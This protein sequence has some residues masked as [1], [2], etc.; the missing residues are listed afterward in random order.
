MPNQ[1]GGLRP[2]VIQIFRQYLG[3]DPNQQEYQGFSDLIIKGTMQPMDLAFFIQGSP[4]FQQKQAPEQFKQYSQALMQGDQDFV[5]GQLGRAYDQASSKFRQMGRPYS[6][7]LESAFAQ[8]ASRTVGDLGAGRQSALANLASSYFGN[9]Q[10]QQLNQGNRITQRSDTLSDAFRNRQYEL[11]DYQKQL[12]DYTKFYEQQRADAK[13]NA[14]LGF[15]SNII[16]GG[17]NAFGSYKG[18]SAL[19]GAS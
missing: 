13:R 17:L 14:W 7:G 1:E 3:R 11:D 12:M 9:V 15:G 6:S 4:E 5:S 2:E 16:S 19:K 8:A 18:M 10:G